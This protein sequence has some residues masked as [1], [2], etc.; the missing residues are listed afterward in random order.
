MEPCQALRY[1]PADSGRFWYPESIGPKG[2]APQSGAAIA[3]RHLLEV[4]LLTAL[5]T[6]L[7][8]VHL[9]VVARPLYVLGALILAWMNL[10]RSP[11]Q[12]LVFSLWIWTTA[13]FARR[14][15]R[16]SGRISTEQ[17]HPG[18]PESAGGA[19]AETDPHKF[20]LVA[21][22]GNRARGAALDPRHIRPGRELLQR[23]NL[24]G[25]R[26]IGSGLGYPAHI[27]LLHCRSFAK[28]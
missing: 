18:R 4:G 12:Y 26:R 13:P 22:Q 1:A 10:R 9:A 20:D 2:A 21:A 3:V 24:S 17:H 7:S 14:L 23:G 28:N 25:N 15:R 8:A 27:L 19:D 6:L 11:W 16:L 5:V